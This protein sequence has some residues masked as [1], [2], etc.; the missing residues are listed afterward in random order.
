[1]DHLWKHA[2]R[3]GWIAVAIFVLV[4][5]V[6]AAAQTEPQAADLPVTRVVLFTS[7]VGYFEHSG[8]VTGDATLEMPVETEQMDDLL[9]SLVLQD[10]DGGTIRPVR[11]PSRDPLGRILQGYDLDLTGQPSLAE[12]LE[13]A[14]GE[15]VRVEAAS[16]HEGA[17]VSVERQDDPERGP[18]TFLTLN[19]AEGLVR[20]ELA[21]VRRIQFVDEALQDQ[22]E[23]A[24][25]A[26]AE[27]RS[28]ASR[29][30]R[31]SFE[32]DGERRVRI[33][34]VREMPVWKTS[35][36][37]VVAEDGTADLQ[38]WAI[39]DNPTDMDLRDVELAFV[40][41]QP[42]SF[43]TDLYEPVYVERP[44]V[45]VSTAPALV[46]PQYEG[47]FES[48]RS[49]DGAAAESAAPQAD[50][51]Q[52]APAPAP[53][54]MDAGVAAMAEGTRTGAT[55]AYRV[56]APVTVERHQSAMVPIVSQS[57]EARRISVFDA[58]VLP[59]RPLRGVRITN[60][61]GLHLAAGTVTVFDEGGFA[62]NARMG[63]LLPDEDR[64]LTYAVDLELMVDVSGSAEPER[65]TAVRLQEGLLQTEVRHRLSTAY[66]I[67]SSAPE[68]RFLVIEHPKRTGYEVVAPGPA[69]EETPSALRFGVAIAGDNAAETAS[70]AP[71]A[72]ATVPTHLTCEANAE[73]IL[74]VVMERV[75]SREL[76]IAN[77]TPD[78]IV[79][80]LENVEL[81]DEDRALLN[82]ILDLKR[83]IVSLDRR[84][85]ETEA[86]LGEIVREQER[87]RQNMAAL[88]RNSSL[89]RRYV[90]DL[91]AQEDTIDEL[92][93]ELE[94]LRTERRA[95][96]ERLDELVRGL[97]AG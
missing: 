93:E 10:L 57:V 54:L 55:F 83:Q 90:A 17:I 58:D 42:I 91:E 25:A 45:S 89:Y 11:Y 88:D 36:R 38:G 5:P 87:I 13:Q 50:A 85:A 69:P 7:G 9:Q 3:A 21:E 28:D 8:T 6:S 76:A 26:L 80:Y 15:R 29:T 20:V 61:T 94:S 95:L 48:A 60:D 82:Q 47:A 86:S 78:Q 64:L 77:V 44:R 31:L 30:V 23:A 52:L 67:G 59:V 71:P 41:G 22:L 16:T 68:D 63:D 51:L 53:R 2:T 72:E 79:F 12:L 81:S 27:V 14:R 66:R 24:L 39:V 56:A 46:A 18:R 43:V 35:Y 62:G 75:E 97:G 19:T 49:A 1:M 4:S 65:V 92:Q 74:E 34:Y 73:C 40:A 37:L 84:I 32:G 33:G 96:Q 70:S